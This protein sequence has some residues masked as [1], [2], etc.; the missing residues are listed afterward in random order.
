MFQ[1]RRVRTSKTG[2]TSFSHHHCWPMLRIFGHTIVDM[3]SGYHVFSGRFVKSS[4]VLPG[5]F[6]IE[7]EL[8]LHAIQ[9]GVPIVEVKKTPYYA[10]PSG[11]HSK[12]DTCRDGFNILGTPEALPLGASADLLWRNR[13]SAG[14]RVHHAR[15]P[16]L[17]HLH[18]RGTRSSPA[19]RH[20]ID[21][22]DVAGTHVGYL[23]VGARHRHAW[24]P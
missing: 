1:Q 2:Q 3:L 23:R 11:S 21:R 8:A 13:T 17:R 24:A 18:G 4:P 9:L 14:D 10:R 7:T 20:V 15:D 19:Y 22:Q 5:G 16:D 12:L 6:E